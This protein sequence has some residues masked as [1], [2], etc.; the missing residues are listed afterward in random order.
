MKFA[1][2]GVVYAN[3]D[4]ACIYNKLFFSTH[5]TSKAYPTGI[6]DPKLLIFIRAV[7]SYLYFPRQ[8]FI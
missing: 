6:P 8:E 3:K 2:S 5:T 1:L 4:A 7:T